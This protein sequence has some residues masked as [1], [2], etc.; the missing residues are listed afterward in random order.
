VTDFSKCFFSCLQDSFGGNSNAVLIANLCPAMRDYMLSYATLNFASKTKTIVNKPVVQEVIEKTIIKRH[1][2]LS[3]QCIPEKKTR[4]EAKKPAPALSPLIKNQKNVQKQVD[5]ISER[6]GSLEKTLL[7]QIKSAGNTDN[8]ILDEAVA[9]ATAIQL[10]VVKEQLA[11]IKKNDVVTENTQAS[12]TSFNKKGGLFI[13]TV[14]L[15]GDQCSGT[16]PSGH[17]HV[18]QEDT[19]L[20]DTIFSRNSVI[21]LQFD[22]CN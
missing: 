18:C 5:S 10:K 9:K 7:S 4:R 14:A 17:L 12:S 11:A 2:D 16:S 20:K 1:S 6:L 15:T 13:F 19:S 21:S 22:L 8:K 3:L